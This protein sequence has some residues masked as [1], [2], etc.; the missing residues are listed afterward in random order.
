MCAIWYAGVSSVLLLLLSGPVQAQ[1]VE[2]TGRAVI[3]ISV[4]QA[5]EGVD[6][7]SQYPLDPTS[8][9]RAVGAG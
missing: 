7:W 3:E 2:V 4:N 9:C 8:V 5:R 1:T 6:G